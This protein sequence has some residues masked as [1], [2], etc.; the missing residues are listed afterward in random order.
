MNQEI[1]DFLTDKPKEPFNKRQWFQDGLLDIYI[2]AQ[3][4]YHESKVISAVTLASFEVKSDDPDDLEKN[5]GKGIFTSFLN[6]VE[7][8]A[9][10][11]GYDCIKVENV[12]NSR[13]A[14][15]LKRRG[16]TVKKNGDDEMC[17]T[18]VKLYI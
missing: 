9:P 10:K 8:L 16:Y 2:R 14:D 7:E 13:L 11:L 15:F 18:L 17:P 1:I 6:E 5:F 3:Y 4:T 12:L